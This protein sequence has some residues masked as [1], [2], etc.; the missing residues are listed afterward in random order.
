[1]RTDE[2]GIKIVQNFLS[3][4]DFVSLLQYLNQTW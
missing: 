3:Q 4:K 2:N 1:M